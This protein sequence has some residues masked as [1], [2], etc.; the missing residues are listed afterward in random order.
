M[1][2]QESLQFALAAA[3]L[4]HSLPGDALRMSAAEVAALGAARGYD[5]RR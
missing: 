2:E 3:C 1:S 5:V 4:K